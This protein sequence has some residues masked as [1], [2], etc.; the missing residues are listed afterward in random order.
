MER[1]LYVRINSPTKNGDIKFEDIKNPKNEYLDTK[2]KT[3][4]AIRA[5]MTIIGRRKYFL[6]A[7][8][9]KGLELR[10]SYLRLVNLRNSSKIT[11]SF[12]FGNSSIISFIQIIIKDNIGLSTKIQW[13]T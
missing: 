6:E 13:W 1:W 7:G 10:E 2:F 3:D 12:H 11:S 8:E 4:F 9:S 5:I